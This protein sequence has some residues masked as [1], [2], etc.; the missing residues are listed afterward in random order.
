M[1]KNAIIALADGTIFKGYSLGAEG[2]TIGEV[3][4]NTSMAGYQEILTDPSYAGQIVTLTYPLIGN[5]GTNET[6]CESSK[7]YLEGFVIKENSIY[8]SNWRSQWDLETFLKRY[9]IVG[10][11]GVDTRALARHIR[12]FGAQTGIISTTDTNPESLIN[13]A[14]ASPGIIGKDLVKHVTCTEVWESKVG[15]QA[16]RLKT[17]DSQLMTHDSRLKNVVV[18]DCGVKYNIVRSLSNCG[19]NVTVVPAHTKADK[20]LAMK[21]DGILLSNG[22]GDPEAVSYMVENTKQLLGKKPILGICLGHQI[23]ALSLGYSTY[24]LKFGHHGANQPVMD[25]TTRKVEITAQNHGFTVDAD[26]RKGNAFG[27][28]EITH[29]N[30]NDKSVEGLVCKDIPA[31]SVQYHPEASPGPHDAAYMFERFIKLMENA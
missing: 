1:R 7:P 5:Y 21:P 2:E 18:Y 10:I 29:I 19:C 26:S 4:F 15:S 14:K 17:Q 24:K 6:D 9:G 30:L 20:V 8:P 28:V 16:S 12:D 31:F 13:K 25:L 11:Q 22:P 27:R 3:V 23:M